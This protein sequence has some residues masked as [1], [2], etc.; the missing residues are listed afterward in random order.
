MIPTCPALYYYKKKLIIYIIKYNINDKKETK[1]Y[2]ASD[3]V[4]HN[5]ACVISGLSQQ[6]KTDSVVPDMARRVTDWL[7][8]SYLLLLQGR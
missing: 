4:C 2:W 7:S 5:N 6:C 1:L 3:T 8:D